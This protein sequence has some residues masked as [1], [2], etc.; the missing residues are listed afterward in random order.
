M[1]LLLRPGISLASP[2]TFVQMFKY[3]RFHYFL[4]YVSLQLVP[5]LPKYTEFPRWRRLGLFPLG[6]AP[7]FRFQT[8]QSRYFI[9]FYVYLYSFYLL[10]ANTK[11][12]PLSIRPS[13]VTLRNVS[14]VVFFSFNRLK[15]IISVLVPWMIVDCNLAVRLPSA[16]QLCALAQFQNDRF[17]ALLQTLNLGQVKQDIF[18]PACDSLTKFVVLESSH[19]LYCIPCKIWTSV[20]Y[21]KIRL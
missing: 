21:F 19:V 13:R 14:T 16:F 12:T 11:G 5:V 6:S 17:L 10:T 8:N 2:K 18:S 9:M 20:V 4:K 1:L 15:M 7:F 3:R